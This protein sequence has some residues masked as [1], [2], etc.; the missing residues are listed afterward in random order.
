M[1]Q[2]RA[3]WGV[4]LRRSLRSQVRSLR[5]LAPRARA[6]AIAAALPVAGEGEFDALAGEL[7]DLAARR[8]EAASLAALAG[9][10]TRL[11]AP[12][13]ERLQ[14]ASIGRWGEI[15]AL[16]AEK[17]HTPFRVS[18]ARLAADVPDVALADRLAPLIRDRDDEVRGAAEAA[19]IDL[20]VR[21]VREGTRAWWDSAEAA[22]THAA[23]EYE[24]TRS[25]AAVI[26]VLRLLAGPAAPSPGGP[27]RAILADESHPIHGAAR[28][29]IRRS[30]RT[31]SVGDAWRLLRHPPLAPACLDRIQR[32]DGAEPNSDWGELL[33]LGHLIA[34]P[35]RAAGLRR[36]AARGG[37]AAVFEPIVVAAADVADGEAERAA[38]PLILG[39][40]G[41]RPAELD[42]LA[43]RL[44]SGPSP[45]VRYRLVRAGA[46]R[47]PMVLPFVLD[48][49]FDAD[50][51]CARSAV[52]AVAPWRRIGRTPEPPLDAA[53]KGLR[54]SP[55]AAVRRLG[56]EVRIDGADLFMGDARSRLAARD[57]LRRD[58]GR[59]L[60]EVRGRLT[61]GDEAASVAAARLAV[62]LGIVA[63]V[64]IELLSV[65]QAAGHQGRRAATAAAALA[66]LSSASSF[67]ALHALLGA[68]DDRVRANALDALVRRARWAG[69]DDSARSRIGS[70]AAEFRSE[71]EHHRVRAGALRGGFL[72]GTAA[73][74]AG[75]ADVAGLGS[76]LGDDRPMHRIAGL[77][78]A[79]R[80][81]PEGLRDG[82][83]EI[84]RRVSGLVRED[85]EPAVR[86]RAG[87]CAVA[88]MARFR[89]D[90]TSR[91]AARLEAE[92]PAEVSP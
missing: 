1:T 35:H 47:R 82:W 81:A 34:H 58:P 2:S 59:V 69:T 40:A 57:L 41:V 21:A 74:G 52:L 22:V 11:S 71:R 14:D 10:W 61:S 8:P 65:L 83:G 85:P 25:A 63:E 32:G 75:A 89:S 28:Q 17:T 87:R 12:A 92:H 55:H 15:A 45:R 18:L 66:H 88:L 67:D 7:L 39:A 56:R 76:M 13:R 73:G 4:M 72:I 5:G 62:D 29:M 78:L 49:C 16:L 3:K 77:W 33:G 26:A 46:A 37:G 70:L 86:V 42:R 90:W 53:A 19:L 24:G 23:E 44:L 48:L 38:A 6:G 54:R 50:V 64:E 30:P 68:P 36:L 27:L 31:V 9:C 80:V 60:V 79:E 51:R 84:A 91:A 20:A 43:S